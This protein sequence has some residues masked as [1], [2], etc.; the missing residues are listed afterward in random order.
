MAL[1]GEERPQLYRFER[2]SC[3]PTELHASCKPQRTGD[4]AASSHPRRIRSSHSRTHHAEGAKRRDKS[5]GTLA[6]PTGVHNPSLRME[7]QQV[8]GH[9]FS[10]PLCRAQSA[11]HLTSTPTSIEVLGGCDQVA[12]LVDPCPRRGFRVYVANG[13]SNSSI[14]A[15]QTVDAQRCRARAFHHGK[16]SIPLG[17]PT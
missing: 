17:L 2:S 1:G 16:R 15:I 10:L 5:A 13:E 8:G 7:Q 4:K 12:Q 6:S 14:Q 3:Q 11:K 9:V